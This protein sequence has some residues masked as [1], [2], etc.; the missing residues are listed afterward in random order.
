MGHRGAGARK[1]GLR[2]MQRWRLLADPGVCGSVV[3][4]GGGVA[5]CVSEIPVK[6]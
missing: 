1:G 2:S 4:R 5:G 6:C 3:V